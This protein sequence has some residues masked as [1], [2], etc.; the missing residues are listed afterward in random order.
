M[1]LNNTILLAL[2]FTLMASMLTSMEK[3][4]PE[5]SQS[6]AGYD[7]AMCLLEKAI[8]K[9]LENSA[10]PSE[11][12][13]E[14]RNM[15][16]ECDFV[17]T[18][19]IAETE[20]ISMIQRKFKEK[21]PDLTIKDL[22]GTYCDLNLV[23][24]TLTCPER[25]TAIHYENTVKA[26]NFTID[27]P[28]TEQDFQQIK[29]LMK[30]NFFELVSLG[31][32]DKIRFTLMPHIKNVVIHQFVRKMNQSVDSLIAMRLGKEKLTQAKVICNA[33]NQVIG[34]ITYK[35]G[36]WK[37]YIEQ[38]AIDKNYRKQG[39]GRM[40]IEHITELEKQAKCE[41]VW[42]TAAP[43]AIEFYKK[44]GFE[45]SPKIGNFFTQQYY[46]CHKDLNK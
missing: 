44:V 40:L 1:K 35:P 14:L 42:L 33:D 25:H 6:T 43:S 11:A 34:F 20:C 17:R 18:A 2:S 46:K 4:E 30:S 21:F 27:R 22:E 38:F 9:L 8:D 10:H 31:L 39:L 28:I 45:S 29:D 19:V 5:I 15:L 24:N 41:I 26:G 37:T 12:C 7:I 36:V 23:Y 13:Y 32:E 3:P 16:K